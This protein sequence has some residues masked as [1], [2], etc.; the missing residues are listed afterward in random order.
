MGGLGERCSEGFFA[1][2]RD[3]SFVFMIAMFFTIE[4]SR[5]CRLGVGGGAPEL[6]DRACTSLGVG[7][8]G[9]FDG[10]VRDFGFEWV[11]LDV[12]VGDCRPGDVSGVRKLLGL[13]AAVFTI[14]A[15]AHIH[16]NVSNSLV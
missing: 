12:W 3:S 14:F 7:L 16:E 2:V 5:S 4:A 9:V 15:I 11:E 1:A 6:E 10:F 8:F 13:E